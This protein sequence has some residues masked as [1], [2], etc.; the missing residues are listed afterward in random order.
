MANSFI[1]WTQDIVRNKLMKT[2]GKIYCMTSSG[3]RKQI[4]SYGAISAAKACLES[5]SRQLSME[6]ATKGIAVNAL[7]AG[8]T[9]TPALRKI[10]GTEK[11]IDNALQRN[12][13]G[14]LTQTS[15]VA[16]FILDNYK[17][18]S[19]WFTGNVVITAVGLQ[20]MW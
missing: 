3:A 4:E 16:D 7:M 12:H 5:Y 9:Y 13:H 8:V 14:R 20:G 10:P 19:S 15:D 17:N 18:N 1:Y 6:L 11:I 2:G